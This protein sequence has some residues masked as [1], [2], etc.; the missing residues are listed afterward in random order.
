MHK[1]YRL[2]T[3]YYIIIIYNILQ[4]YCHIYIIVLRIYV[5]RIQAIDLFN[6]EY[7]K[8]QNNQC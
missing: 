8:F 1:L 3:I 5:G 6:L 7:I 4:Y 2:Y